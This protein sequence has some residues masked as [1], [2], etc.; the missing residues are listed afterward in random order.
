MKSVLFH[1]PN[2]SISQTIHNDKTLVFRLCHF[3]SQLKGKVSSFLGNLFIKEYMGR[4]V[5]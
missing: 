1:F 5:A 2:C 4:A 3:S